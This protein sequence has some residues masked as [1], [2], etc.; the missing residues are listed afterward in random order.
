MA[1]DPLAAQPPIIR[2]AARW[3][4]MPQAAILWEALQV[5]KRNA[6][7]WRL[8]Y[9]AARASLETRYAHDN[10]GAGEGQ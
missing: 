7:F 10:P 1:A 3:D 5:E 6:E 9:E 2:R 8:K 4:A